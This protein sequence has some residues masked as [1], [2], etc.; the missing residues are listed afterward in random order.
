MKVANEAAELFDR[1]SNPD[2]LHNVAG[3]PENAAV[4][5]RLEKEL[6]RQI[7][8]VGISGEELPAGRVEPR[9]KRKKKAE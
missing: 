3:N 4:I 1:E 6:Q 9:K 7:E 2:Q 8:A 5:K